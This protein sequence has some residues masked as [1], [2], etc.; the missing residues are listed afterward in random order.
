MRLSEQQ[1]DVLRYLAT[2]PRGVTAW[3]VARD[4]LNAPR[5]DDGHVRSQGAVNSLRSLR[6]RE[7]VKLDGDRWSITGHGL[8][9]L[10]DFAFGEIA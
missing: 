5:D 7:F 6:R 3:R 4:V 9:A 10:S 2:Q 8:R 1:V